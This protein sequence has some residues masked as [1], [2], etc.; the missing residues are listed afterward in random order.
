MFCYFYFG[1]FSIS[2][3]FFVEKV[4]FSFLSHY[5]LS[6]PK[7]LN[8]LFH[9]VTLMDVRYH[10]GQLLEQQSVLGMRSFIV[11]NRNGSYY[12]H[13]SS[14]R[15]GGWFVRDRSELFRVLAEVRVDSQPVRMLTHRFHLVEQDHGDFRESFFM[16]L[17]EQAF[18]YR[19][20]KPQDIE[21]VF[22]VAKIGDARVWGRIYTV[23]VDSGRTIIRFTK[24]TDKRED[25]TN[26]V[27]EFVFFV[28]INKAGEIIKRWDE[29]H[30]AD[31]H[32][33]SEHYSRLLFRA[34]RLWDTDVIITANQDLNDAIDANKRVESELPRFIAEYRSSAEKLSQ[35]SLASAAA[36]WSLGNFTL[37][38]SLFSGVPFSHDSHQELL[39]LKGLS[40]SEVPIKDYLL[41]H[42]RALTSDGYVLNNHHSSSD[43]K[44][45]DAGLLFYQLHGITDQLSADEKK[46]AAEKVA[47]VLDNIE[48][49][50]VNGLV[51]SV[52]KTPVELQALHCALYAAAYR[53]T[54]NAVYQEKEKQL[55]ETLRSLYWNGKILARSLA[56]FNAAS[57][58]F[59]AAYY[60]PELL[61]TEE[62]KICF[63]NVLKTV[64]LAWGGV[65]DGVHSTLWLNN[66]AG[67]VL[68]RADKKLFNDYVEKIYAASSDELLWKNCLGVAGA[69]SS[70]ELL[71]SDGV[72]SLSAATFI[73]LA[74]ALHRHGCS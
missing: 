68:H 44:I 46:Y 23:T 27:D 64:W 2:L 1:F 15:H 67:V 50:M 43:Q 47:D 19:L 45:E 42:V 28:V 35:L 12:Y 48:R 31:E 58:V 5:F 10:V 69:H 25:P 71:R 14:T 65:R 63:N 18:V 52:D 62:W 73:E 70:A 20:S 21:L 11:G 54:K 72:S 55:R 59:L 3:L 13:N 34:L 9:S 8:V 26:G 41:R 49:R 29:K 16:P 60:Y 30:Y 7:L 36:S 57:T 38:L 61:N 33:D 66:I 39:A 22:D 4:I 6:I 40:L 74:T 51:R 56:D 37:G 17:R 32:R 24:K 53:L